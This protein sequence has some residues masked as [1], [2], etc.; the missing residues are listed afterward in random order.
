MQQSSMK[1]TR[2]KWQKWQKYLRT[3]ITT[4]GGAAA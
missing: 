2:K 3:T 4:F 1:Q